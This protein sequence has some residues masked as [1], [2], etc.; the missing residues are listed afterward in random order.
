MTTH[1]GTGAARPVRAS[2]TPAEQMQRALNCG[3][4]RTCQDCGAKVLYLFSRRTYATY[5]TR[6]GKDTFEPR[7]CPD[8]YV[9]DRGPYPAGTLEAMSD[10][11]LMVEMDRAYALQASVVDNGGS[12][13]ASYRA[14]CRCEHVG[15]ELKSRGLTNAYWARCEEPDPV[16]VTPTPD[17]PTADH[18]RGG[19]LSSNTEI[20]R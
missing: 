19:G 4:L 10:D 13:D 15:Q 6:C 16:C 3:D 18:P 2:D 11:R 14:E 5:A 8:G 9:S 12:D 20:S 7:A 1:T 17:A